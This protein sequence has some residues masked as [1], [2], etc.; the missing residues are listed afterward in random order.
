MIDTFR[1]TRALRLTRVVLAVLIV[2]D[3]VTLAYRTLR[4]AVA[5]PLWVESAGWSGVIP[6]SPV[7][8]IS[9]AVVSAVAAILF[10]KREGSLIPGA[11]A[12]VSLRLQHEG[13]AAT[14]GLFE[15]PYYHVGAF[16][17]GWLGGGLI[18]RLLRARPEVPEERS[19]G[20]RV[21]A[22]CG[23]AM[24]AGTWMNAGISKLRDDWFEGAG[25]DV[26]RL[27]V[28]RHTVPGHDTWR[29]P[30]V[31]AI[32]SSPRGAD[33]MAW[34]TL[35]VELSAFGLLLSPRWRAA[36]AVTLV[37]FHVGTFITA[38]IFFVQAA[39]LALCVG[40][41][42]VAIQDRGRGAAGSGASAVSWK[43]T[44][45]KLARVP[46]II[47]SSIGMV[48]T[49]VLLI[50]PRSHRVESLLTS[51]AGSVS[52]QSAS[53][54]LELA[55]FGPVEQATMLDGWSVRTI[56]AESEA[57]LFFLDDGD[58]ECVLEVRPDSPGAARGPF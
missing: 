57:A 9:L 29:E 12:L 48:A 40:L 41:P 10:G 42:W 50:P 43:P 44:R 6:R 45:E 23:T 3:A 27:M 34:A 19:W 55:R 25:G 5:H 17:F 22:L 16:L 13:F 4:G 14:T 52:H 2:F 7:L 58:G 18:A 28:L 1:D 38:G 35:V 51:Q 49:A 56:R 11:L 21:S 32:A 53:P 47:A 37:A 36:T 15:E 8:V 46:A 26:I 39:T 20:E 54:V 31:N 30:I 33:A 24:L